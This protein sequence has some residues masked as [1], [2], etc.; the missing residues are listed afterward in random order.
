MG[1][2]YFILP[3]LFAIF[4]SFLIVRGAAIALML[5]GMDYRKA[6][7]QA[8][9][10]FSGTGFTTKEAESVV[11][12][13]RRRKIIT[14]LIILGNAGVVTVIVTM[15]SSFVGSEGYQ[16]PINIVVFLVGIFIIYIIVSRQ[17]FM[18]KWENYAF[19]KLRKSSVFEEDATED[20]LHLIEGYG[21][22]RAFVK[23][24]SDHKD[25]SLAECRLR[26]MGLLMLGIERAKEWIPNP[27]SNEMIKE[28]DMLILYGPLNVLRSEFKE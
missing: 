20:L 27:K 21:L 17:K 4:F 2:L 11:N 10:A 1:G 22:V 12:H 8:L 7:F 15:T 13:P 18:Q 9:S 25:K 26:E 5:T 3:A 28:G 6:K 16:I 23:S 14:W 19:K 24:D